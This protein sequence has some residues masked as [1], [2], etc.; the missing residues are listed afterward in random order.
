LEKAPCIVNQE[1]TEDQNTNQN[2]GSR[3]QALTEID[4]NVNAEGNMLEDNE[5]EQG[6]ED[7]NED[8]NWDKEEARITTEDRV[9]PGVQSHAAKETVPSATLNMDT[10]VNKPY[11]PVARLAQ[12]NAD[13][14]RAPF[15]S[16]IY[17]RPGRNVQHPHPRRPN[18]GPTNRMIVR[19]HGSPPWAGAGPGRDKDSRLPNGLHLSPTSI[20]PPLPYA[21][22]LRCEVARR[23]TY[24]NEALGMGL[25]FGEPNGPGGS[26]NGSQQG[27]Y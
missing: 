26:S 4:L 9:R 22:T 8:P 12:R 20:G 21:D 13:P 1:L 10:Q 3:F 27:S 15:S 17:N 2:Y 5:K 25:S 14:R 19:D 16:T 23:P 24:A 18:L 7:I 6:T 11:Q